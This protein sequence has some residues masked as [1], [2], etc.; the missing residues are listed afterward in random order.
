MRSA[1]GIADT[2]MLRGVVHERLEASG[3]PVLP[4]AQVAAAVWE[5]LGS[6]ETGHVWVVQPGRPPLDFRF[7]SVPG[8]RVDGEAVGTPPPLAQR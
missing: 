2:P 3:F 5:A 7:A 1:A 6:G 8:P 4:P